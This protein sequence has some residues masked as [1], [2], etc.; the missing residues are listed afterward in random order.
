MQLKHGFHDKNEKNN[1]EKK[2]PVERFQPSDK[3]AFY[4]NNK[5]GESN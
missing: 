1:G 2:R 3:I 4:G 5:K